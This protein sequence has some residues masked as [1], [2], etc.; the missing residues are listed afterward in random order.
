MEREETAFCMSEMLA[1]SETVIVCLLII[2]S[3]FALTSPVN[4]EILSLFTVAPPSKFL[5]AS[6]IKIYEGRFFR[7]D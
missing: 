7:F 5:E 3:P 2:G 4:H 6:I 1:S